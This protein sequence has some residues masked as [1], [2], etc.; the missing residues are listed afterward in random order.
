[1]RA[2]HLASGSPR[3]RALLEAAGVHLLPHPVA[4]IDEAWR[5]GEHPVIYAR[6]MAA[7]KA[8]AAS[9]RRG[10]SLEAPLLTADTTVWTHPSRPPLGKPEN[11]AAAAAMLA[12]LR[13]ARRHQVTTAFAVQRPSGT[14]EVAHETTQV[15]L[16]PPP[17]EALADYLAGD[18]WCDKAGGYAI[19][20]V[21]A[22]WVHRIEGSYANVVGLPVAQVLDHIWPSP[23]AP[24]EGT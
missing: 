4:D 17:R 21:A 15:W 5:G 14:L 23:A 8:A 22:A 3:R 13:R 16:C 19:Q 12:R 10:S 24:Q 6:R 18:E 1:M 7:E 20:G 11:A 2:L 9:A